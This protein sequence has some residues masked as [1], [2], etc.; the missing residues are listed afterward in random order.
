MDEL[1]NN[2]IILEKF[3]LKNSLNKALDLDNQEY[4]KIVQ[5]SFNSDKFE[6]SQDIMEFVDEF[7]YILD[8][9]S[10]RVS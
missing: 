4:V 9:C 2:Y 8:T 3:Y 1:V 10:K 7:C 6:S 5:K